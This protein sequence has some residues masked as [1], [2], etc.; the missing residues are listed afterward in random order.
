MSLMSS[1]YTGVSGLKASQNAL[2]TTAHNLANTE[3][4]GYSRQQ[5][6]Q[7]DLSY[8]TWG[9]THIS[10]LQ[11][12]TG[13]NIST[14]KQFRNVFLDQSYRKE[15]GRQGFYEAQGEAVDEVE[16]IFGELEG[17]TFQDQLEDL[18][19]SIEELQKNP[20][21]TARNTLIQTAVNFLQ[22]AQT[23]SQQ[24]KDYQVNLNTQI[25]DDVDQINSL[26]KQISDL[27]DKICQYESGG[28]ENANDLRDERNNL[29]DQLAQVVN[30]SYSESS[31][32]KVT[33]YAE[34]HLLV[35]ESHTY[36]MGTKKVS[37]S[38]DMLKPVWISD[39][40]DV[41]NMDKLS[42]ATDSNNTDLD[43]GSLKGLLI[44]RGTQAANYTYNYQSS[45]YSST[46][47]Y[48]A[49]T[50]DYETNT[51]PSVIMTIQAQFDTLIH[52]IV[53]TINNVLCPTDEVTVTISGSTK[54]LKVLSDDASVGTDSDSTAGEMLFTRKSTDTWRS[55][56]AE[57]ISGS[58]GLLTSSSKIYIEEDA[59]NNY[60]LFTLG[61][62]EVNPDILADNSKFPI[63]DSESG[64]YDMDMLDKLT[65]QW[66]STFATLSPSTLTKYNF[67]DFYTAMIGDLATRGEQY[68][69][70]SENQATLVSN[71]D[72]ERQEA[73]GVSS[74]EELTNLIKFQHAY[75]ASSRYITV[76]SEMLE[77]LITSLGS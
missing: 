29:L 8:Y 14:V 36:T 74:D 23:I 37:D 62:I 13:T 71:I 53:T 49:A 75:N 65:S 56:T 69:A 66:Q 30:I 51:D 34:G 70:M 2:N 45:D 11:S 67:N 68:D 43:I 50:K 64:D 15:I 9:Y 59:S 41:Y 40:T 24:L 77:Y 27:N 54:T 21:N 17:V 42:A 60:T 1:F 38:S 32:G 3:T 10:T 28:V 22:R 7:T 39:G 48:A 52:G 76:I 25:S 47:A 6:L 46:S 16:S 63:A 31:N 19:T 58:N 12:G 20:S 61:E 26:A 18:W 35:S 4:T 44:A 72:S 5:V 73:S 57:E 33:V 55:P